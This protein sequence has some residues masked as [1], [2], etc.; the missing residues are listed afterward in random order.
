M[1]VV[2]LW[3]GCSNSGVC[4]SISGHGASHWLVA[5]KLLALF[6]TIHAHCPTRSHTCKFRQRWDPWENVRAR[7]E[8][9]DLLL[10]NHRDKDHDS[11]SHIVA[12]L[13]VPCTWPSR[14]RG[15]SNWLITDRRVIPPPLR[16]FIGET[17]N[18]IYSRPIGRRRW[19]IADMFLHRSRDNSGLL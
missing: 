10:H 11:W 5:H 15:A 17:I 19:L 6:T 3:R 1:F 4:S 18:T 9:I 2:V 14:H 16:S 12:W 8:C 13:P 7:M